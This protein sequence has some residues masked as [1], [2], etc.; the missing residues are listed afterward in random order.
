MQMQCIQFLLEIPS[1]KVRLQT[2][3]VMTQPIILC[4]FFH[5]AY[6]KV[7]KNLASSPFWS[8]ASVDEIYGQDGVTVC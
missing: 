5:S 6:R 2:M 1:A 7:Q 3:R 4:K 8:L